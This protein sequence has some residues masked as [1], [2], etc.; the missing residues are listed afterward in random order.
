MLGTIL[1]GEP[2][3][4]ENAVS[5]KRAAVCC[6]MTGSYTHLDVYKRQGV[7][8]ARLENAMMLLSQVFFP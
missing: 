1:R 5:L 8:P 7:D 2:F 6:F 4:M 3:S